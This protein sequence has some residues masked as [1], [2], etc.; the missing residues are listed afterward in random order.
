MVAGYVY[1]ALTQFVALGGYADT[2]VLVYTLS[3]IVEGL[4]VTVKIIS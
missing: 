1:S 3:L 2:K 4:S